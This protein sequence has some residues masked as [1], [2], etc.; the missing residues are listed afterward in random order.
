MQAVLTVP[1]DTNMFVR[2]EEENILKM[3]AITHKRNEGD[4]SQR[5]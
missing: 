5:K 1:V 3:S 4:H 2:S